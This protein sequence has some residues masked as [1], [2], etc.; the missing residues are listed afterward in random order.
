M[1]NFRKCF[2]S[3]ET[4][5]LKRELEEWIENGCEKNQH[6]LGGGDERLEPNVIL[7]GSQ[8]AHHGIHGVW[9]VY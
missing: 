8:R 6:L 7:K 5:G 9:R 1:N 4:R 2:L 3:V